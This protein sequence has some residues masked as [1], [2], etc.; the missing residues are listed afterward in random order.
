M[1]VRNLYEIK[2]KND[3]KN[4]CGYLYYWI[5]ENV[6]GLFGNNWNK[7]HGKE[8]ILALFDTG[9]KIINE[10]KI[11][12]CFYDYDTEISLEELR[13]KKDLFDYF[14]NYNNI[15]AYVNSEET[16]KEK[17]C[18]YFTYIKKIYRKYIKKC[19]IY[20]DHYSYM[21]TCSDY[22]RIYYP[23][24]FLCKLNCPVDELH[25]DSNKAVKSF[26]FFSINIS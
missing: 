21:N 26:L 13:E 24:D 18:K 5:Y 23:N 11:N 19:C 1:L 12:E 8:P 20:Y 2:K 16:G 9:Y 10:L 6:W 22:F 3:K 15:D 25:H 14:N 17:Y 4:S 7:I